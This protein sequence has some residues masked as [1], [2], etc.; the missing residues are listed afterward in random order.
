MLVAADEVGAL[1]TTFTVNTAPALTFEHGPPLDWI[2][3]IV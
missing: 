1:G 2:A 3:A